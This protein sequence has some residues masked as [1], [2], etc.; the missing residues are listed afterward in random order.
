MRSRS[1]K[2]AAPP[3]PPPPLTVCVIPSHSSNAHTCYLWTSKYVKTRCCCMHCVIH[4]DEG[5]ACSVRTQ[6]TSFSRMRSRSRMSAAG[7]PP[8]QPVILCPRNSPLLTRSSMIYYRMTASP[9]EPQGPETLT[10]HTNHLFKPHA[11][12][13]S[14]TGS[15]PAAAAVPRKV[16]AEHP[17]L[18]TRTPKRT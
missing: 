14:Q 2:S 13:L 16:G 12:S 5:T 9:I 1:R 7:L 4:R 6:D 15:C 11:Q 18:S 3:P 8:P 17:R 10:H